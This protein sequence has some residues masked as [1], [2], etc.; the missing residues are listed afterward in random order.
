MELAV[1]KAYEV[2]RRSR[3]EI[4]PWGDGNMRLVHDGEC[5]IPAILEPQFWQAAEQS[6]QAEGA[7]GYHGH[8]QSH[9]LQLWRK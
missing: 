2:G 8:G 1:E 4:A 7:I 9:R 3:A 5:K 6:A